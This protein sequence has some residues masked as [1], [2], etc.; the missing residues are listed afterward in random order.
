M[1]H[2]TLIVIV[3]GGFLLQSCSRDKVPVQIDRE[4]Y[5]MATD[6]NGFVWYQYNDSLY[7]KSPGSGHNWPFLKTRYNTIAQSQLDA[8]GKVLANA[9]FPEGSVVVKELFSDSATIVRYAVL[10]KNSS[11]D[12]ADENGWV[13]GYVNSDGSTAT[14]AVHKGNTCISCHQQAGNIDYMLMNLYFP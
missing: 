1:R 6:L 11:N 12:F 2:Y 4:L 5:E 10:W 14:S 13:W 9:S 8:N 3:I 7:E